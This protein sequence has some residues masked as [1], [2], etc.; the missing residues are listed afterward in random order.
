M[1]VWD[2]EQI[3]PFSDTDTLLAEL[4][5][6]VAAFAAVRD[7]L[8]ENLSCER[9]MELYKQTEAISLL[10][11]K[12]SG[13]ASL[14]FAADTS[15]AKISAHKSKISHI[16]TEHSNSLRFF[17]L[18]FK[19]LSAAA[20][21]TYIDAAGPYAYALVEMR[22]FTPHTLTESEEKIVSLK[23]LS[24]VSA[25]VK[26]YSIITNKF[27]YDWNGKMISAEELKVYC[28]SPQREER[29]K[30]Y[31]LRFAKYAAE[32]SILGEIY[33]SIV[34]DWRNENVGLRNFSSPISVRNLAND[35]PD[36]AIEAL[37]A[38]VRNNVGLFQEYFALKAKVCKLD[39]FDRFD[40][41]APYLLVA[42]EYSYEDSKQLVLDTYG[43]FSSEMKKMAE[44]IFSANHVHSD[45]VANKRGGAF[46]SSVLKDLPP[47]ILLNHTNKIRDLFTMMHEF[48]HG[49]HHM[50]ARGQTE[51]TFHSSLPL[52]ETASTFGEMLLTKR[53]LAEA[54]TDDEK[55]Y[56]LLRTLDGHYASIVRQA[57]FVL[58]EQQAHEKIAAGATV[59]ELNELYLSL[60]QEQFGDMPVPACFAHEWSYIP[61][62]FHTPFYCYAYA[63]GELLVLALFKMYEEQGETFI[64]KYLKILS[65]G[66]SAPAAEILAEIGVDICSEDF[67]QQGFDLIAEE[68]EKLKK[69]TS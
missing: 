3:Y 65:A 34:L 15:D 18:W 68:V 58:F 22:N 61:H 4:D 35:V 2:L 63:F 23:D 39:A 32:E 29:V 5:S 64:P 38:V 19:S 11:S 6:N 53:L 36:A 37:L 16:L 59:H 45:L 69:L 41:Y 8:T 66:G 20:A 42:K 47:F 24:G 26:L 62:M 67:W 57:Y 50:L 54:A 13:Y 25:V 12:L 31:E 55:I 27:L 51:F 1:V 43:Q 17:G 40:L 7:E 28:E 33:R 14:A 44:Q 52:A 48:G 10:C 56:L 9:F 49:I 60:L 21:Q 46:C 30:S